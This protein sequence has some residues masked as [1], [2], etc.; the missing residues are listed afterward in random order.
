MVGIHVP[1]H[2][3]IFSPSWSQ[4]P[5]DASEFCHLLFRP[6]KPLRNRDLTRPIIFLGI[7]TKRKA[8]PRVA[9][10]SKLFCAVAFWA[11]GQS[12]FIKE[13]RVLTHVG[14]PPECH[15]AQRLVR[16]QVQTSC[17]EGSR[18]LVTCTSHM[19]VVSMLATF[20]GHLRLGDISSQ[21]GT[22][23]SCHLVGVP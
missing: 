8:A 6:S 18:A 14:F 9:D 4:R 11:P 21:G 2:L 19:V 12:I 1:D 17:Y 3:C 22:V 16:Y 7:L 20:A 13:G 5:H 15:R 23:P 10:V